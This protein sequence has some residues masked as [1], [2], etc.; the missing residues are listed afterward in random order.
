VCRIYDRL[1]NF[2][3]FRTGGS[4]HHYTYFMKIRV[5]IQTLLTVIVVCIAQAA[6]EAPALPHTLSITPE[7]KKAFRA[8]D[9]IEVRS[10][11][12]TATKFQIGGTYRLA[13]ICR[14]QSLKNATLSLGNTSEPGSEAISAKEGSS[15]YKPLTNGTT[16]FDITFT[17]LRPGLL[18]LT[19]YDMDS[20]NK[21]DNASAGV[22]LGDVVFQ[23]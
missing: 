20:G 22:Y 19:I 10:V 7:I 8:D 13:G 18:H 4:K 15:L 11:T 3:A 5:A 16:A 6:P 21:T 1:Y 23:R 9:A 17:V 12:G 2:R 14:Q